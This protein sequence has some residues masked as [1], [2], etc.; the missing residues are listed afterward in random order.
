MREIRI[1]KHKIKHRI[2]KSMRQVEYTS[3]P[4][5]KR[6]MLVMEMRK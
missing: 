5:F 3:V 4:K 1:R 2:E 6:E